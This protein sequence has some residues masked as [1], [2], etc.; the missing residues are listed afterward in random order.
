MVKSLDDEKAGTILLLEVTY[1]LLE[2]YAA[3]CGSVSSP[4]L[5]QEYAIVKQ[6]LLAA[7]LE[8]AFRLATA[9]TLFSTGKFFTSEEASGASSFI[10]LGEF[11]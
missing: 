11:I 10:L 8:H 3:A 5:A 6:E 4:K 1:V 9:G 2:A 7:A